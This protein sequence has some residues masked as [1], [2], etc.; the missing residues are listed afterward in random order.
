M[1]FINLAEKTVNAKLV[2]Y[3]VG[4]GGKTTSLKSV[5]G[6][7]CPKDEV[8]LVSINTEQDSTLLF[9]FLPI[10]LGQVEGFKIRVRGFTVPGQAQYVV[11]RKYVLSGADAV[12][13][14]FDTQKDR[15]E[16]NLEAI[17]DL[18]MNLAVNG[19][20]WQTIP[21][22]IQ[23][24]KRDLPDV[25]PEEELDKLFRFREVPVYLT[26]AT[27]RQGVFEAFSEA[28]ALMVE[29][30]V[31]HYGLGKGD[32]EPSEVARISRQRLESF[33][34]Q[35]D[36]SDV[37]RHKKDLLTVI[38]SDDASKELKERQRGK[39]RGKKE[40]ADAKSETGSG[41]EL[42]EIDEDLFKDI[43]EEKDSPS[44]SSAKGRGAKT[45]AAK[46]TG[47][48]GQAAAD[49]S[50]GE[51]RGPENFEGGLPSLLDVALSAKF[52]DED[53][54]LLGQAIT[55][56]MELA[57][58]YAELAEYKSLLEK[59]NRELV[60]VNQLI[61]HDLKKPLT[62][63]KTVVGLLQGSHLGELN[64][65]QSDAML[66]ASESVSYMEELVNDILEASRLDY[67]GIRFDFQ[68]MDMTLLI[69]KLIRRLR[70]LLEE[71]GVRVR[72]D[73]LPVIC[74][75][76]S[77]LTK[78]FMNLIGNAI[79]YRDNEKD[80]KRLVI[81]AFEEGDDWVFEVEDNGIGIPADNIECIWEKF[82]RGSNTG[83]VHGSGLGL[84]I[85]RE[86]SRG[87]GGDAAVRSEEC[88]G[89]TFSI[90]L[91]KHPWQ[92]EHSPVS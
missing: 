15:I 20:D 17:E 69:G 74:G 41:L 9:D 57:S 63:F 46:G 77:A 38:V 50:V 47:K 26:V 40:K 87:H 49:P 34:E 80:L 75:D 1:G 29:E 10:D 48:K 83:S 79:N 28:V 8:K 32:I 44:E 67:D 16:E 52:S 11:M 90:R 19:L 85:I 55:S 13:M 31:S 82:Q 33:V 86:L 5:H 91:P 68:E 12:V 54:E 27:E 25:L 36:E 18:K 45:S 65:R 56:N 72:V 64:Q 60:E 76:E 14:V 22:V 89:T 23:Y 35:Q 58:L 84:Y 7:M 81:R 6:I 43:E 21:L 51:A 62:V 73:P 30:K 39:K 70:F 66:N 3:G 78:I 92:P 42:L 2:Y 61:S 37:E 53:S 88:A 71:T 59:K 4:L 24:N